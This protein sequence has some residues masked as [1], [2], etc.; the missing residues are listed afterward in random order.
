MTAIRIDK[1]LKRHH[2][3]CLSF[4]LIFGSGNSA[5]Q[6]LDE[7][8]IEALFEVKVMELASGIEQQVNKSPSVVSVITAEEIKAFGAKNI[9][10]ALEMV[11][12]V[13][14][15]PSS[16]VGMW[17]VVTFRGIF[18]NTNSQVLW[19]LDGDRI[20]YSVQGGF[21]QNFYLPVGNIKKI[22]VIRGPASALYGA[23]AFAGVINLVT[24]DE[25]EKT[26]VSA[27]IGS[28]E[29]RSIT[30]R[31]TFSIDPYW[32]LSLAGEYFERGSDDSRIIDSDVQSFFDSLFG[33]N[34]S[35]A[36]GGIDDDIEQTALSAKLSS[37][38][39]KI[40]SHFIY[41]DSPQMIGVSNTLGAGS[42]RKS[43][44]WNHSIAYDSANR[45]SNW[46]FRPSMQLYEFSQETELEVFPDGTILPIGGDGN[47]DFSSSNL[48]TFPDGFL[49]FPS[50][51][52]KVLELDLPVHHLGFKD[53]QLRYSLGYRKEEVV[54]GEI[55]NFGPG[56]IDGTQPIV[57]SSF[58][59]DVTNTP[60]IFLEDTRREIFYISAQDI[61]RLS[62]DLE[63]TLGVRF[64]DYSDVGST[65]T[66]RATLV[67]EPDDKITAKLIYGNAFRAPSFADKAIKNN[68]AQLGNPNVDNE[69][70]NSYEISLSYLY[71]KNTWLNL[72][73][74]RYNAKSLIAFVPEEDNPTNSTAQNI[75][76]L[77]GK[78]VELEM[79]WQ[80]SQNIKVDVNYSWQST[81]NDLAGQQQ[82]FVP[83]QLAFL[84]VNWSFNETWQINLSS[85]G[86]MD[87]ERED[88]DQRRKVSDYW[89]TSLNLQYNYK[90]WNLNTAIKNLLNDDIR[91]PSS[92]ASLISGDFPMNER[93]GFIELSYQF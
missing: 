76:E 24:F 3:F 90:N 31:S 13:H 60:F 4:M 2:W 58:L 49:G 43:T 1:S 39:W 55:K 52:Y 29:Q 35:L 41:V 22:E 86:V 59:T 45:M 68:P 26:V 37:E 74:Y 47:V 92:V 48:V 40:S 36:P 9:Q 65:I 88:F 70:L 78:G 44:I 38:Q 11:P 33:S 85:R 51:D 87:R 75:N 91:E 89:L 62:E 66:P 93:N 19:L 83:Q 16:V 21:D 34:A 27:S 8:S 56:V 28:F 80:V 82:P 17:P 77:K 12:G 64:D 32:S 61:W 69:E 71:N 57:D 67:W 25:A 30:A 6:E 50:G 54:T 63:A 5:S 79:F 81:D 72:N 15:V 18:S 84:R 42:F 14:V 7:L 20:S 46:R 10:E 73:M 23:E 53:H